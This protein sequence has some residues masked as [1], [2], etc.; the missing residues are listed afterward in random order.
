[1]NKLEALRLFCAAAESGNFRQTALHL[2]VSPQAVTRAVAFLEQEFGGLLFVRNTRHTSITPFGQEIYA[3]ARAALN[4][5]DALFQRFSEKERTRETGLVR[6][7]LPEVDDFGVLEYVLDGLRDFP[8]IVLDWRSGNALSNTDREQIDVGIRVGPA[9]DGDFIIKPLAALHLQTV[10]APA[11][12][13]KLG[14]PATSHDLQ[15]HFP[16]VGM[17]NINSGR[18]FEYDYPDGSFAPEQPA[19][20]TPN[21]AQGLQAVLQGRAVG[22]FAAWTV[23][24]HIR[25]GRLKTVLPSQ[26]MTLHD[27]QLYVY[28]PGRHRDTARVK[29]VFD[30]L[31]EAVEQKIRE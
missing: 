20:I 15:Q 19:F 12:A 11:L 28:R 24:E 17:L 1:M 14:E 18:L 23:A 25:A 16:L 8:E 29:R 22:Q 31:A 6:V 4:H 21:A 10:M 3:E 13:E 26:E 7:A 2:G 27:W 30:L 5:T 9:P